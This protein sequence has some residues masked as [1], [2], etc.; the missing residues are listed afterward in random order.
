[1]VT[2]IAQVHE[3]VGSTPAIPPIFCSY[4][5]QLIPAYLGQ[6]KEVLALQ[7]VALELFSWDGLAAQWSVLNFYLSPI[8]SHPESQNLNMN[9]VAAASAIVRDKLGIAHFESDVEIIKIN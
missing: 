8:H 6:D 9:S 4:C 2:T 1:M 3:V 5:A 7:S